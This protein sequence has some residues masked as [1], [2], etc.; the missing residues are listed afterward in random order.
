MAGS[1]N[2]HQEQLCMTNGHLPHLARLI[3]DDRHFAS[4]IRRVHID[5]S[6]FIY[7]AGLKHYGIP[8]FRQAWGRLGKFR[9]IIGSNVPL[10]A[11]SRTQPPHIKAA[12][13][14]YFLI[15][16]MSYVPSS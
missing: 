15:E 16:E 6:H 12:I 14:K 10:Q 5:E 2:L 8:A 4:L 13:I 3:A 1:S 11:L 7:T 9:I